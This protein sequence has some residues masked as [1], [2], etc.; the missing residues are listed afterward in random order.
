MKRVLAVVLVTAAVLWAR[1]LGGTGGEVPSTALALGFALVVAMVSGDLLRRFRL[2]RLTGY[3]LFGVL[4]GPYLGNVITAPMARELQTVNGIATVMIAFIAGL[5]LNFE[6]LGRRIAGT[7]RL[8]VATLGTTTLGLLAVVWI[9]WSWLPIAPGAT[10][11]TKLAMVTLFV[12]IT[13]SFSP[14]MTAAVISE[15]G[16]RGPAER[17]GARDCRPRRPRG[18]RALLAR[19]A[20]RAAHARS[21]HG[22]R[23]RTWRPGSRGRSAA[24]SRS[25]SL[26]G[27]VFALYLRYVG[28]EVTLVLLGVCALLSQVGATQ[29]FEPLLAA[30]AAGMVIQNVAVPQGDALNV[31]IQRGALPGARRLLRRHRGVA[32]APHAL[33]V[34]L[35]RRGARR[36]PHRAASDRR[37]GR[38]QGVGHRPPDRRVRVDRTHLA[39]GHHAGPRVGAGAPSS[40]RGAARSR[41][42]SSR[43][44]RSTNWSGRCC[45]GSASRR[46]ASSTPARARPLIVVS[47]REPYLHNY[48]EQRRHHGRRRRQAA[49]P[50]RST[51]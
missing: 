7:A 46:P 26:V 13:I 33:H 1:R 27:A 47:N 17:A 10:G 44:S 25:A 49:W 3:L 12:I 28:R 31:A 32:P 29:G 16:A 40:R 51:R 35:D 11:V 50:W 36:D 38:P 30:M 5:M 21:R 9:A 34:R 22:R 42:C 45:S 41:R 48:D 23:T 15:T 37:R 24:R 14:T 6:R 39:G 43:S 2:P 4:V 8:I 18:A 20:A 19:A